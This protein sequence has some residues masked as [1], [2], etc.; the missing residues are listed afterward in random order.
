MEDQPN[1]SKFT[2]EEIQIIKDNFAEFLECIDEKPVKDWMQKN[3]S[4]FLKNKLKEL[5]ERLNSRDIFS[6]RIFFKGNVF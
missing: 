3:E 4:K 1:K 6:P 5:E 2:D